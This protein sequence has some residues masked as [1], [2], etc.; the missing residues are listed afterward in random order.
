MACDFNVVVSMDLK[1]IGKHQFLHLIDNS[2]RCSA[3][4]IG[5]YKNKEVSVEK[6]FTHWI[7]VFGCPIKFLSDNGG[8]YNNSL[9]RD[10]VELLNVEVLTTA[11]ESPWSNGITE[12]HNVI[13]ANMV[14]QVQQESNCSFEIAMLGVFRQKCIKIVCRYS[15]NQ[16]VFGKNSNIPTSLNSKL[17]SMEGKTSS[18]I[19]A[20][21]LNAMHAARKAFIEN[22]TS[23]KLRCPIKRKCRIACHFTTI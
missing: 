19:I 3:S 15:P 22:E 2:T 18:Q 8:E 1:S 14:Q 20:D 13:I 17:P 9:F 7:A 11:V 23:Q 4:A 21:N 16:L 5:K 10:M 12:R 6:I